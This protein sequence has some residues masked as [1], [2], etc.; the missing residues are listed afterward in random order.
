MT[1]DVEREAA[2]GRWAFKL[3]FRQDRSVGECGLCESLDVYEG[4]DLIGLS[5][6]VGFPKLLFP[7]L[8]LVYV[9]TKYFTL[10]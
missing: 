10:N 6:Y 1:K 9:G 3:E 4:V 8:F 7:L 5:S 2:P